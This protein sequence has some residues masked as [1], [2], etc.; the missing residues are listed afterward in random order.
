MKSSLA[1]SNSSTSGRSLASGL[2]FKDNLKRPSNGK[3]A[4]VRGFLVGEAARMAATKKE[5]STISSSSKDGGGTINSQQNKKK[6]K[7]NATTNSKSSGLLV[8][9]LNRSAKFG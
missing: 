7:Q 1:A 8:G 2:D 3:S 5:S 6:Q 4:P 9:L